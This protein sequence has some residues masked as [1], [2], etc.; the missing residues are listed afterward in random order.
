MVTLGKMIHGSD[1]KWGVPPLLDML[2][3]HLWIHS[4]G[5]PRVNEHRCGKPMVS[6]GKQSTTQEA[7]ATLWIY[8]KNTVVLM[9]GD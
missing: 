1:S 2:M 6:L 7:T 4:D 8:G 5:T 3:G 9:V